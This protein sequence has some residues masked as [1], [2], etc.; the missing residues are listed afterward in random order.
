MSSSINTMNTS[1]QT[2]LHN[3]K[4]K[5]V[6][7]WQ[8]LRVQCAGI[9]IWTKTIHFHVSSYFLRCI[10]TWTSPSYT[11]LHK[12]TAL[13]A[14]PSQSWSPS[15]PP[16]F[17]TFQYFN[18]FGCFSTEK[19]MCKRTSSSG[20]CYSWNDRNVW[21]VDALWECVNFWWLVWQWSKSST[22]ILMLWFVFTDDHHLKAHFLP[23]PCPPCSSFL[24]A[25]LS[26]TSP[27]S[28][29]TSHHHIH[30]PPTSISYVHLWNKPSLQL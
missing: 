16:C 29:P 24:L 7:S 15:S 1:T 14:C 25:P 22:L 11:V 27:H 20:M 17:A 8:L 19:P 10:F 23:P 6:F 3:L 4:K 26:H 12:H 13:S 21:E 28:P 5:I 9:Y 2:M 18:V 30:F